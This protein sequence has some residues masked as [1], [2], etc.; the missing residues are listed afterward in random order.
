MSDVEVG[1]RA[2][3]W[4]VPRLFDDITL[5]HLI[6]AVTLAL[7][8]FFGFED[9]AFKFATQM[10][11]LLVILKPRMLVR[12]E[13]WAVIS[14]VATAVLVLSWSTSDNHKYLLVYWLWA[15]ALATYLHDHADVILSSHARF[16]LI[17][18]FLVAAVQKTFSPTYMSGE[19]FELKLLT[20]DRFQAFGHLLGIDRTISD[21]VSVELSSLKSPLAVYENNSRV[22]SSNDHV[23]TMAQVITWYDL[24]VQYLIG[25]LF[26]IR[27]KWSDLLGHIVLL[28]FIYTTY[29]AAPVFGFGWLLA[30]Y[31][32]TLVK[33]RSPLLEL[34]YA[35]A[36]VAV[37]CY[38]SPW[39]DWVLN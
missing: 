24:L 34:A 11:M 21:T 15:V 12:P 27:R 30:I 39:R 13:L 26:L 28:A 38:Q 31:G 8:I 25:A 20:D 32:V 22:I 17:F 4:N 19:M 10:A 23:R 37:L 16:F 36:F 3:A 29:I 1:A 9:I 14:L 33:G 6:T 7:V 35:G 5:L 2:S 18:V